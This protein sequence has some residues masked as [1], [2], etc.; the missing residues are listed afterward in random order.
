[1]NELKHRLESELEQLMLG[2]RGNRQFQQML[3]VYLRLSARDR[4]AVNIL[5]LLIS[6]YFI[7]SVFISPALKHLSTAE[8]NYQQQIENHAWMLE[9]VSY[10]HL[11][12]PTKRI[13]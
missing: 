3:H 1:M 11:T 2:V 5:T 13:V 7:T 8:K 6:L 10:T 4:L 12:L 9:P